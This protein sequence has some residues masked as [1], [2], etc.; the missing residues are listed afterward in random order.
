MRDQKTTKREIAEL[1]LRIGAVQFRPHKPF[2]LASGNPS[3]VYVDC[4]KIISFPRVRNQ[5]I[6][7][8]VARVQEIHKTETF[9]CIAGG[10]TAGIPFAS[11][12]AHQMDLPMAYIRKQPKGYGRNAQIEGV[13]ESEQNIL[14]IEDLATDG[15]SKLR[16]VDAIRKVGALC[17]HTAVILAYGIFPDRERK[18]TEAGVELHRLCGLGDVFAVAKSR[19]ELQDGADTVIDA[20]IDNP[21]LWQKQNQFPPRT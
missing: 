11:F 2:K 19:G 9:D 15:G 21:E 5:I 18:L 20:F 17:Q 12:V 1:L 3:P 8:L 14:L 16:F 7:G 4:R 13:I 6:D 10:E